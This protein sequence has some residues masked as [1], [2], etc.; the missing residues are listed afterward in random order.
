[1]QP[2]AQAHEA[3][4]AKAQARVQGRRFGQDYPRDVD[5]VDLEVLLAEVERLAGLVEQ[6]EQEAREPGD[7]GLPP[8]LA[9]V[10]E[11]VAQG[12]TNAEIA[13]QLYLTEK[14]VKNMV[15][16]VLI[17]LDVDNR[18]KAAVAWLTR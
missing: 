8:R 3:R 17:R 12:A 16:E 7:L 13:A 2:E 18:T 11:L 4:V 10:L 15:S 14:T 5:R 1:M 9:A 6:Q